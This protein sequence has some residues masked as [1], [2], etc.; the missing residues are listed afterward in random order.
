[1]ERFGYEL[2]SGAGS[3]HNQN[4]GIRWR[5]ALLPDCSEEVFAI[6]LNSFYFPAVY[7]DGSTG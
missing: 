4:R 7:P 1:M 3:A 5:H 6:L 2:F